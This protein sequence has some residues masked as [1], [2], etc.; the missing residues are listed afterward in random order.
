MSEKFGEWISVKDKL[1]ND[2][3]PVLVLH[4]N[5]IGI[6]LH[7]ISAYFNNKWAKG[8]IVTYWMPL[9]ESPKTE[10]TRG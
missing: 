9:P 4:D 1:P 8:Q 6:N 2:C 10:D 7:S 5:D 3:R